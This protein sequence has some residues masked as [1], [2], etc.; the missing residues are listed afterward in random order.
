M[1]K[2]IREITKKISAMLIVMTMLVSI[3]I[4]AITPIFSIAAEIPQLRASNLR[5]ATLLATYERYNG[6]KGNVIMYKDIQ[7]RVWD[8]YEKKVDD[9]NNREADDYYCLR[10]GAHINTFD[11]NDYNVIEIMNSDGSGARNPDD[12]LKDIKD[13][14]DNGLSSYI[15]FRGDSKK[16]IIALQWLSKNMYWDSSNFGS[17]SNI[18]YMRRNL[19]D[20][21]KTYASSCGVTS[22]N[23]V[24]DLVLSAEQISVIQQYVVWQFVEHADEQT[25]YQG[26]ISQLSD[27]DNF[28]YNNGNKLFTNDEQKK[29]AYAIYAT[30]KKG[31]EEYSNDQSKYSIQ[32][33]SVADEV[34][35]ENIPYQDD[36]QVNK[37]GDKQYEI[38]VKMEGVNQKILNG[39]E[40]NLVIK[41]QNNN[42]ISYTNKRN[43]KNDGRT[44]VTIEDNTKNIRQL[45]NQEYY[46]RFNTNQELTET[47]IQYKINVYYKP[48]LDKVNARFYIRGPEYGLN[49][50]PVLGISKEISKKDKSSRITIKKKKDINI[51]LAL[52]KQI[53]KVKDHLN[54]DVI[55]YDETVNDTDDDNEYRL[56]SIENNS[57]STTRKY[58]MDKKP[59]RVGTNAE[60]TYRLTVFNEGEEAAV[61]KEVTDYY[62]KNMIAVSE[63]NNVK[64]KVS[65]VYEP[66]LTKPSKFPESRQTSDVNVTIVNASGSETYNQAEITV[67]GSTGISVDAKKAFDIEITFTVDNNVKP[68]DILVNMA[69]ITQYGYEQNGYQPC[70]EKDKDIDSIQGN[71]N[72]D[73]YNRAIETARNVDYFD[74]IIDKQDLCEYDDEDDYDFEQVIVGEFDLALR[75]FI[76]KV[77]DTDLSEENS[78]EPQITSGSALKM[79][80]QERGLNS[81]TTTI[82]YIHK[83]NPITVKTGDII[84]YTI[85]VYNEGF[86]DGYAKKIIDHLP[87]GLE[88]VP[89]EQSEI[90]R[91]NGWQVD[92]S[93]NS[94]VKT[95][96]LQNDV[97][98]AMN[99]SSGVVRL[100]ARFK[101]IDDTR[102]Y[103]RDVKIECK[104]SE[105][106]SNSIKNLTNVSEISDYGYKVGNSYIEANHSGVD[107]D[108]TENNVFSGDTKTNNDYYQYQD[109]KYNKNNYY[110]IEDD[111]DFENVRVLSFD[112]ALRKFITK[113]N[114]A[115]IENSREPI[116]NTYSAENL[117]S[118]GTAIYWHDKRA[119]PVESGKI[120]TYKIRVYNEGY[121]EGYAKEITDY[122]PDG[123]EFVPTEQSEINR[124]NGWQVDSSDSRIIRTHILENQK[125]PAGRGSIE[126][127]DNM[128][129]GRPANCYKDIELECKVTSNENDV[130]LTNV[131]EITDYGYGDP[132]KNTQKKGVDA[133]SEQGNVYTINE[134]IQDIPTYIDSKNV[135]DVHNIAV[136]KDKDNQDKQVQNIPGLQDDDDFETVKVTAKFNYNFELIKTYEGGQTPEQGAKFNVKRLDGVNTTT[137]ISDEEIK[138][139]KTFTHNDADTNH[140]YGYGIVEKE[141][142][143]G[144]INILEGYR[145]QLA[146]YLDDDAKLQKASDFNGYDYSD[147]GFILFNGESVVENTNELYSKINL[148]INNN[149]N[150]PKVTLT[151][152]NPKIEGNYNIKLLKTDGVNAL[153]GAEFKITTDDRQEYNKTTGNEAV[154]VLTRNI[155]DLQKDD[156]YEFEEI[157]V[158]DGYIKL[159]DKFSLYVHKQLSGSSYEISSISFD[160][161]NFKE[162][163]EI[164][165][166]VTLEDGTTAEV[167]ASM[168]RNTITITVP[169]PPIKGQY[170]INLIKVD[171]KDGK[172]KLPGVTFD[173]TVKKGEE[174]IT[175]KDVNGNEI[176]TTELVTN[177]EGKIAIPNVKIE[178]QAEYTYEFK[179]TKVPEGY[180]MLE[181]PIKLTL[182]TI[183]SE[184]KY[185]L[186][187][188]VDLVGDAKMNKEGNTI[189]ITVGNGEFDLALRKFITATRTH[190]GT[191]EEKTTEITSRIPVFEI[192]EEGKYR[193][194]HSKE[195]VLVGS[196]NVV[197]YTLRAYN[198]GSINGYAKEIKDDIP[199]GLEFLPEDKINKE[200]GWKMIDEKGNEV[201]E[202]N[203]AK[204]IVTDYLSKEKEK[205]AGS[206]LI[207][208]FKVEEMK[209]P[210]YKEVKVAFKVTIPDGDDRIII[211]QAQ[212]SD[213]SDEDGDEV[214]DKDS[215]PDEWK[216]G[217][218]DQDIEKVKVLE[219]DLSLRKWVT[220]AIV[221]ENGKENVVETGHNAEDDPEEIVKVD[222][223]N[224][225][226]N[227]VVVK[228][229][230]KI[231]VTNEGEIAGYA[232]EITDYIPE[233]LRFDKS[234]NPL[235]KEEEGKVVTDQLKD[236]LLQPG[237][238]KEVSIL[239]TWINKENNMG[240]KENVAE[241]SKDENEYGTPDRDSV[242][243]NKVPGEDDIDDAPV[244]LTVKT[245]QAIVYVGI[246]TMVVTILGI[247]IILI[248]KYVLN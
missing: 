233:G 105:S 222:L 139:S 135:D 225:S 167:K 145:I 33:T 43:I 11:N 64:A 125:I 206:N 45:A 42:E 184:G 141:S 179:E 180:I 170:N 99:G 7:H 242:P 38:H 181:K 217:E 138:N 237:E 112:M 152:P 68:G 136:I 118:N 6:K 239:L 137:I 134:T 37:I 200:Y 197:E 210:E 175:L 28:K 8:Y 66:N 195:P 106:G 182:K 123:L 70:N 183:V 201:K 19:V 157:N 142:A 27:L 69:E 116:I 126:Q 202:V 74:N 211:N 25:Y 172:T 163:E 60:I 36:V 80:R 161:Q 5:K 174:T 144:Y 229:E 133:D 119:V 108:S 220:K 47:T 41:D 230:Y 232:K 90:N 67:N 204:Y 154:D 59:L 55:Y 110:G 149:V 155:I 91:D 192:D 189:T 100:S 121:Y 247:G 173:V 168:N 102:P 58:R 238:S 132:Y 215:T 73:I 208:A 221:I 97:I 219:F 9:Y 169:N 82:D 53:T 159:K 63:S 71:L 21:V 185:I 12:I 81:N 150:P 32:M 156:V 241:I 244:M 76:T 13:I 96:K 171:M 165:T 34:N 65:N 158:P 85:R 218:D 113:V 146:V 199:N 48:T 226:I 143:P 193:Y 198:E 26:A 92:P 35:L 87:D 148:E 130:K 245:G 94:I 164:S 89:T 207:K 44:D 227:K 57:Q 49:K 56:K 51:D 46:I 151:I 20:I 54:G 78:R 3:C 127:Y 128:A 223:K 29:Q 160:G 178:E 101:G 23:K 40:D 190:V 120:V 15:S 166:N 191:E 196:E 31:A 162:N 114:G 62:P 129:K 84:T 103:Y 131:A 240:L 205:E 216:D 104:V 75:K 4:S 224:S 246:T 187:E 194:T 177:E 124:N 212:I 231:R 122:L 107:R 98:T 235:W 24:D 30:L 77:N 203:K 10:G 188:D 22:I 72:R 95:N 61:V 186:A 213:D 111:D 2:G 50:Q 147:K 17:E 18:D 236:T 109:V 16:S 14:N 39:I 248:K 115:N 93:D 176:K 52:T 79:S 153:P 234:D 209:E 83:K 228:F 88:F 117:K 140:V 86:I 214:E 243:N 1:K